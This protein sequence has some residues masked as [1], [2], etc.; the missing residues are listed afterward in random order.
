MSAIQSDVQNDEVV[1]P[2]APAADAAPQKSAREEALEALEARHQ[3]EMAKAN[4]WELPTENEPEPAAAPEP[5]PDQLQQQMND[6]APEPEPAASQP[7][8]VKVKIDGEEA[9]VPVDDLVRQYQKNA[10]ADKRLAEATRLLR[11]AQE[12]EAQRLLREQQ[13]QQYLQQQLEQQQ[14][15]Q[16]PAAQNPA[17]DDSVAARKEFLK[18]LFEGDEDNALTKLD[19]MLAGRQQAPAPAPILDV[20]QIAQTVTQ[21]VQ[22]KLVVESVLTQNRRDYPE[23][24]AD[25]DM[26]A[27]ALA[28]IQRM[29]SEEGTDF[30][31]AL[32]TVS[33]QMATKFGWGAAVPEPGRRE[34]PAPATNPRAQK[35]EAK[36]TIDNV[37]SI[38]TKTAP[39]EPAPEDA[40]S[41][42]AAMKA[43]RAGG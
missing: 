31:A 34:D 6:P 29:Q 37:A 15:Q 27:L 39:N 1:A 20:D 25:P 4:G 18:A 17:G 9:E 22:Q 21:H 35:L 42:I 36:K 8:K 2:A 38:N 11:E 32:D 28:K 26:E 30:F 43:A 7:A 24:Y 16:Q 13:H 14:L 5:A 3:A 19:E 41:I 10:T 33:K 40:S 12:A 23:M